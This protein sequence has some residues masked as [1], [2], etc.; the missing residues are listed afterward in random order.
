MTSLRPFEECIR[1]CNGIAS[2][3]QR[4]LQA[5]IQVKPPASHGV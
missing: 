5:L 3:G 4:R 1:R 2:K